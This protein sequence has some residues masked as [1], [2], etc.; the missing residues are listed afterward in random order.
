MY[1]T[2]SESIASLTQRDT[3]RR[4][5]EKRSAKEKKPAVPWLD[6]RRREGHV[7]SVP[8]HS[9]RTQS[10]FLSPLASCT[11]QCTRAARGGTTP[12]GG[13]H[14][15]RGRKLHSHTGSG[16][17]SHRRGRERYAGI[18]RTESA[19][20]PD[21][22]TPADMLE[23]TMESCPLVSDASPALVPSGKNASLNSCSRYFYVY[24]PVGCLPKRIKTV[25]SQEFA[26]RHTHASR[27]RIARKAIA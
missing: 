4:R 22:V 16:Y 21:C 5:E 19:R 9:A 23:R 14:V 12:R 25:A 10:F 24:P 26:V 3:K 2:R 11:P 20:T 1:T 7:S 17:H 13:A 8:A 27:R 15:Y 18:A 6:A